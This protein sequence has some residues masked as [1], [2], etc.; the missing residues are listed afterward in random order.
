MLQQAHLYTLPVYILFT[1]YGR[2]L[3]DP[4]FLYIDYTSPSNAFLVMGRQ[5]CLVM[6][7]TLAYF[8]N[9]EGHRV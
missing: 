1:R 7:I 5:N 3:C 8:H 9:I 4:A 2:G 6:P